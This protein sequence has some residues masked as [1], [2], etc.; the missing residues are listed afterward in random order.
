MNGVSD[1]DDEDEEMRH[2][3]CQ[4]GVD[5]GLLNLKFLIASISC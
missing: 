4:S 3:I 1:E 2:F 5:I